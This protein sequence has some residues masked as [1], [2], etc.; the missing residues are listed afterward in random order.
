MLTKS[1]KNIII[2]INSLVI[3]KFIDKKHIHYNYLFEMKNN[4][5]TNICSTKYIYFIYKLVKLDENISN[6]SHETRV[7][8]RNTLTSINIY[9]SFPNTNTPLPILKFMKQI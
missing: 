4:L 9:K 2:N 7:E 8:I 6:L 3:N 5:L 1:I